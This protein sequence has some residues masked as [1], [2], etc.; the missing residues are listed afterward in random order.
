MTSTERWTRGRISAIDEL[1][2][3]ADEAKVWAFEQLKERKKTQLDILDEFNARLRAA[4]LANDAAAEPPQISK[5]AFNRTAIKVAILSRRL[6]ETREIAAII[7]PKLDEA[8]DN[9]LTVM[10][11]ETVRLAGSTWRAPVRSRTRWSSTPHCTARTDML[12]AP[13]EPF[14]AWNEVISWPLR[15]VK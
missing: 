10:V 4:S 3:W 15:S 7:A 8:G 2:D 6:Q 12:R 5:S 1:P 13:L 11:A 9:S 14:L